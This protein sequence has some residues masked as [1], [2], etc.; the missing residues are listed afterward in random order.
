LNSGTT[1]VTTGTT[2]G[3]T[4]IV[5]D[6]G[7]ATLE[8]LG[9]GSAAIGS[10]YLGYNAGSKGT[11]LVHGGTWYSLAPY[12]SYNE[13]R[14]GWFGEGTLNVVDGVVTTE[15]MSVGRPAGG[16]G[17]VTVTSGT[18]YDWGYTVIGGGGVGTLT[19]NGGSFTSNAGCALGGTSGTGAISITGGTYGSNNFSMGGGG[20][21]LLDVDGGTFF[22]GKSLI[23]DNGIA[24][25]RS[26]TWLEY[27]YLMVGDGGH[28]RL[29]IT[30]GYV[31]MPL[32]GV[33]FERGTG[34]V[35]ITGGTLAPG[36]ISIETSTLNVNGGRVTTGETWIR[37]GSATISSGTWANESLYLGLGVGTITV[38]G[39]VVTSGSCSLGVYGGSVGNG[40]IS[41]GTWANSGDLAVGVAGTGTLT[42]T[43]G[44]FSVAGTLSTGSLGTINLN[45]GGTLQIGM[46]G[47]TGVLGVATL[48][49][50]GTLIFNRSDASN[51]SGVLSGSGAISKQGTGTL[52]LAGLNTLTGPTTIQQGT[53]Q[54]AHA[55]ALAASTIS[56]LA[57]G[58]LSLTPGLQATVGGLSA[59]AGGLVDVGTGMVTVANG[60]SST[61]LV[62]ALHSGR[63]DG[64]WTGS[65]G[66]TSAAAASAIASTTL[67]SV[68]WLDN[69][70]G[71]MTFGFAAPGDTNLDWRVDILD[72]SNFIAGGKFDT[73]LP[74]TWGE[75]DFNYDG[76]VDILDA[77]DFFATGFYDAGAYNAASESIAAVPEPNGLGVVAVGAGLAGLRAVRRK[78]T[79]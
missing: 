11:V 57:G 65:S 31:S 6:T 15:N 77:A 12:P 10:S 28:G 23:Y 53:V 73:S 49:N 13:M 3:G 29:S 22:S 4:L 78:R 14:V 41:S 19:V 2:F 32:L 36:G 76:A 37:S 30:G 33:G 43:G 42:M 54:L 50:N 45:A 69:G 35:T 39:G 25:V 18:V 60:L 58:V 44:L 79:G 68:G 5:G 61:A 27:N 62:T 51:Y 59:N 17:T 63:A 48:T 16:K 71:S 24:T 66:I 46:G 20:I 52:T 47:T 72:A 55:S 26:G 1:T 8:I 40:I 75:G 74:A 7:T 21:G 34:T 56:P 67:R 70:N 38:N 9:G 64:S